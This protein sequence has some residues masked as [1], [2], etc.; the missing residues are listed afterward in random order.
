MKCVVTVGGSNYFTT[1]T[2]RV[3]C[4]QCVMYVHLL[5]MV[6]RGDLLISL[7]Y[8]PAAKTLEGLL[9]KATN[10]QK[11]DI[12][13]LA[14]ILVC[15]SSYLCGTTKFLHWFII[16]YSVVR[17]YGVMNALKCRTLGATEMRVTESIRKICEQKRRLKRKKLAVLHSVVFQVA[18]SLL[19]ALLRALESSAV[20]KLGRIPLQY[21]CR[22]P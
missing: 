21:R 6:T 14:G 9:L 13:G 5:Q 11:Q 22:V 15:V 7:K 4:V 16:L 1:R 2:V 17:V 20:E 3:V 8:N 18:F 10:L 12:V 19:L